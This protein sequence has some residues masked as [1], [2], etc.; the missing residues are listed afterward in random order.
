M[1]PIVLGRAYLSGL[2]LGISFDELL[3]RAAVGRVEGLSVAQTGGGGGGE[4]AGG[5][6]RGRGGL[7]LQAV[8]GVPPWGQQHPNPGQEPAPELVLVK[9]KC[10]N[11]VVLHFYGHNMNKLLLHGQMYLNHEF[12]TRPI[13]CPLKNGLQANLI[14]TRFLLKSNLY[15]VFQASQWEVALISHIIESSDRLLQERRR[16]I[17]ATV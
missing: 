7:G 17:V 12:S 11:H 5:R 10:T 13:L 3:S 6:G 14:Q 1:Q 16:H 9:V 15:T 2:V 8:E 4:G